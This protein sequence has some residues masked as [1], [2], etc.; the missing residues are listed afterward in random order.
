MLK[1]ARILLPGI[2]I[3]NALSGCIT[4][5]KTTVKTGGPEIVSFRALPFSLSD[6]KLLSGP[7]L[8]ATELDINTLL[9]YEPDRLLSKFYSEAGLKPKANTTWDGKMRQLQG[10]ALVITSAHVQ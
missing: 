8:H 10:I 9:S 7:F 6:V 2:I 5:Y 1:I 3:L 4:H